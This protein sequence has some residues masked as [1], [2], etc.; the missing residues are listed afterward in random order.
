MAGHNFHSEGLEN[1]LLTSESLAFHNRLFREAGQT[2][3]LSWGALQ[4][5]PVCLSAV[6]LSEYLTTHICNFLLFC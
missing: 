6:I 3:C 5:L 1:S 2:S 4:P